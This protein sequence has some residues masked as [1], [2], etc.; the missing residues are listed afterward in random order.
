MRSAGNAG[1]AG[2]EL[3]EP[4]K[5]MT[6]RK[7]HAEHVGTS[8]GGSVATSVRD[9]HRR[10]SE[11][12]A[13]PVRSRTR[14]A[15]SARGPS[16]AADTR[17]HDDGWHRAPDLTGSHHA[18]SRL[19]RTNGRCR[20]TARQTALGDASLGQAIS[21]CGAPAR[22][23]RSQAACACRTE[24][25]DTPIHRSQLACLRPRPGPVAPNVPLGGTIGRT[26]RR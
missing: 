26:G 7:S 5:P 2:D 14:S 20:L 8:G 16:P 23:Y 13:R 4:A 11:V 25:P 3:P 9:A 12:T 21:A 6:R 24:S 17:D 18:R 15:R 10:T 1:K 19:A 22:R